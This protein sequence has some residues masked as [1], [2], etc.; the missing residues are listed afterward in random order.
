MRHFKHIG[1]LSKWRNWSG[2]YGHT[3]DGLTYAVLSDLPSRL[4]GSLGLSLYGQASA[5]HGV[6]LGFFVNGSEKSCTGFH[7]VRQKD[8]CGLKESSA[9][10]YMAPVFWRFGPYILLR[11]HPGF[12]RRAS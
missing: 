10:L 8:L 5:S 11:E 3:Y 7:G 6:A 4:Q 1:G 9:R 12:K 2:N